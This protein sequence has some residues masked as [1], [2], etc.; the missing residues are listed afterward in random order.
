MKPISPPTT[1]KR[2]RSERSAS[3]GADS[4]E[5]PIVPSAATEVHTKVLYKRHSSLTRRNESL[6]TYAA[7]FIPMVLL[8]LFAEG[9]G[10][11]GRVFVHLAWWTFAVAQY[12]F[13]V[14]GIEGTHDAKTDVPVRG[15]AL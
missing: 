11:M 3:L 9:S 13:H 5:E 15:Y 2:R 12:T 14:H 6:A 10:S 1:P 4:A 8:S 7:V